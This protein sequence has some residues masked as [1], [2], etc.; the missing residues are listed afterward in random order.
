MTLSRPKKSEN[1]PI[2]KAIYQLISKT[3]LKSFYI[4]LI[5]ALIKNVKSKNKSRENQ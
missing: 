5:M 4:V 3:S 2:K 1:H